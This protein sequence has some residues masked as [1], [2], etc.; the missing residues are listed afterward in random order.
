MKARILLSLRVLIGAIAAISLGWAG[1]TAVRY[2]KTSPRFETRNV[3]PMGMKHVTESQVIAAARGGLDSGMNVFA[4]DL[5][6]VRKGVEDLRW[7]RYATAQRVLPDQITIRIVEREPVGLAR[8]NGQMYRFDADGVILDPPGPDDDAS[9][10]VLDGLRANDL[11][12]NRQRAA[13]YLK[14]LAELDAASLSE[15]HIAEPGGN[16]FVVALNDPMLVN[17][18]NEDFRARWARYLRVRPEIR[19]KYPGAALAD[20]RFRGQVVVRMT[21]DAESSGGKTKWRS[22]KRNAL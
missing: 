5:D 22:E 17:L 12:G 8:V 4:V 20:L 11:D 14:T 2:A 10:P 21:V 19:N 1:Y 3:L 18:G 13:T 15:V 9:F 6:A 7:V 16:V